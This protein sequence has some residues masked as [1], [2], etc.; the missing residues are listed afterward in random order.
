MLQVRRLSGFSGQAILLDTTTP[1]AHLNLTTNHL[2]VKAK[3]SLAGE[4]SLADVEAL[5]GSMVS[6]CPNVHL[7]LWRKHRCCGVGR[8]AG[9]LILVHLVQFEGLVFGHAGHQSPS[10]GRQIHGGMC[11]LPLAS[12][13]ALDFGTQQA[14]E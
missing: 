14:T 11:E 4:K 10:D 1:L 7:R 6:A 13:R 12:W 2:L 9:D 3:M 5:N 8:H